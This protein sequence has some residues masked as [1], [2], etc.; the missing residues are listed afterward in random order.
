VVEA[1]ATVSYDSTGRPVQAL[2]SEGA[3]TESVATTASILLRFNRFLLP[4]KI[5]RQ[6]VCLRPNTDPISSIDD[7]LAPFQPFTEPQYEPTARQVIYRLPAG[8]R[9]AAD[10]LYR[11]TVFT[12]AELSDSGFFA[13]DG[14]PLDRSY[15]F[16]FRTQP[17][18]GDEHEEALPSAERYCAAVR[19]FDACGGDAACEQGCTPK[20]I[21]PSCFN[22]GAIG[23]QPAAKVFSSCVSANCH[24]PSDPLGAAD[25]SRVAAGL[26]LHSEQSV[27]DTAIGV[28]AH[29]SAQGESV[30][31]ADQSP[32]RFGRAMPL[33][34]P[35][36]P[37]NSY[38]LYKLIANPL[39]H[40]A[41]ARAAD[42]SLAASIER[43]RA[44]MLSGL[45][46][47]AAA[48]SN[49]SGLVWHDDDP[50][51]TRS[52]AQLRAIE[53]WIAHGAVL[54]CAP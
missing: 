26:D 53:A 44:G 40:P 54:R 39:N 34:D 48:D 46:M 15:E 29:G 51:G 18:G 43:L 11:L 22:K 20:C 37:G 13:F 47:P 19:C 42:P 31:S 1:R 25:S 30:G 4:H 12:T 17:P 5:I 27:A 23:R 7:C 49:P 16:T 36:N 35:Q 8:A 28:V 9:L 52:F 2:L 33:I 10:T 50:D 6:S 32:E 41:A 14:A 45:P 24:G 21:E 38:L 3:L